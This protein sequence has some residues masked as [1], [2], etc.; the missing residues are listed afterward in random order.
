MIP[1]Y[2]RIFLVVFLLPAAG[3]AP[4]SPGQEPPSP[5]EPPVENGVFT[6]NSP[7]PACRYQV[8]PG[9][10]AY[11][12]TPVVV[13]DGWSEPVMLA[14]PLTD[15]CPNDAI[16]LS[17]D[18]KTLYFFWSPTV[19][20]TYEELLHIHTGTY[21]AERVGDDP[22]VFGEPRFFDLQ[23]GAEDGSVDGV[24]SFTPEGDFVYF[25]ST[26]A[27]NLGYNAT[28][29]TD[30]FL[31]IYVAPMVDGEPGVGVNVGEP[32]NSVYLDGEH[33]LH[34]DGKRLFF[35]STRPGG[36]G[37]GPD[38]WVSERAGG[39][40]S[41]P[42][43]LGAPINST[44]W[45]GQPGFAADHP[46]TMYFVSQRDGPSSIYQ[47]TFNGTTWSEPEMVITGYVGEGSPVR[48]S[49]ISAAKSDVPGRLT[50]VVVL[51][52]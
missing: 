50:D 9:R 1:F 18:G 29:P 16:E 33:A 49:G 10:T 40:W 12:E 46:D 7:R 15:A 51:L 43:N 11:H 5:D 17:R 2:V 37:D 23:K 24:P 35:T 26:R 36:V 38:I 41:E 42:V 22:G 30:D 47:S 48:I 39:G 32:V 20:G 4:D 13:A 19:N 27:A 3:C 6:H 44:G 28:P 34:P 52:Q 21:R 25:H 31:D 8:A 14:A 45:D